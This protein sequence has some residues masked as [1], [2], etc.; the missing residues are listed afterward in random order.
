MI[1]NLDKYNRN[2]GTDKPNKYKLE[3]FCI[4]QGSLNGGH[5]YAVCNN[6]CTD[7]T[8]YQANSDVLSTINKDWLT[9]NKSRFCNHPYK[10][11]TCKTI[12]ID[13]LIEHYGTPDLIKSDVECG[14][15]E[16]ICS[17][18]QK[19]KL[20][21]FEWAAEYNS[22]TINCINYLNKLGYT[23]YYMQLRDN[24][25]FRPKDSDFYC[26]DTVKIKLSNTQPKKD[27]GMIWCK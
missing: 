1:L 3:G 25:L 4:H 7:I 24:Y 2:Y 18:T 9:E 14:E 27:W 22:I 11:I 17:L 23:Q 21:C 15:Y 6:N 26:I 20:L 19:V 16:C 13:K 10:E 8:F 12:T 5:Y